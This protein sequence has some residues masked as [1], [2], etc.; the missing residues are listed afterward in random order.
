VRPVAIVTDSTHYTTRELIDAAG[1][2]EVSLYVSDAGGSR[3]ESEI[4]DYDAFYAQLRQEA[5]L[6]TTSQPSIGDFLAAYQP[7]LADGRDVVSIQLAGGISGTVGTAAAAKAL[8][9]EQ[10]SEGR[11]EVYDARTA[12]GGLGCVVLAAAAAARGG[13]YV[14]AVLARAREARDALEIWFCI[15]TLAY[16]QRGGRIGRA[17]AWLGGALQVKPILSLDAE[18]TPVERVRTSKRAFERMVDYMRRRRN[19][20]A[21]G[22]VVQHIQAPDRAA[23]LVARGRELFGCEPQW[24]SEVGPVIGTYT[25]PGLIGVGGVPARLLR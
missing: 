6:P 20:G 24:V 25:G 21:D 4:T 5:T 23:E 2:R 11:V 10:G 17:Q 22:W 1:V 16:L 12:C 8:L 13:G 18:I 9:D 7:L 14:D 19:D 3:R 15:D